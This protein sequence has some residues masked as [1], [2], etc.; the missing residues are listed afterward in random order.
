MDIDDRVRPF[1]QK[2]FGSLPA[3]PIRAGIVGQMCRF[4]ENHVDPLLLQ[5]VAKFAGH[6][7]YT[8]LSVDALRSVGGHIAFVAVGDIHRDQLA[9][10]VGFCAC[11]RQSA[12]R[13]ENG[14]RFADLQPGYI[15]HGFFADF[16][17]DGVA[18]LHG[19]NAIKD[20]VGTDVFVA[21]V[22]FAADGEQICARSIHRDMQR[23]GQ[24]VC[25]GGRQKC[26]I[27]RERQRQRQSKARE[28]FFHAC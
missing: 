14:L 24:I 4:I 12:F 18:V 9:R 17:S 2:A 20:V 22:D 28:F 7:V 27:Q 23:F 16:F 8:A 25:G 11:G 3:S 5:S 1:L 10:I 21:F 26:G 15:R 13:R 19:R 6:V